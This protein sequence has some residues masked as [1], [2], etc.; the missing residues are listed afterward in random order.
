[1]VEFDLNSIEK[2]KRKDISK[3]RKMEKPNLA[4]SG[5]RAPALLDR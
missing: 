3:F 4:Q 1:M 5:V 2:M